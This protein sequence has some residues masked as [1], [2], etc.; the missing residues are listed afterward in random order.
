MK[1]GLGLCGYACTPWIWEPVTEYLNSQ[2]DLKLVSWPTS[3]L[4]H[5]H[6]VNDFTHWVIN[7]QIT[8]CRFIIGHSMGGLVATQ[9]AALTPQIEQVILLDSFVTT[10]TN[11][12]QMLFLPTLGKPIQNKIINM[13]N[14]ERIHY[15]PQL[16]DNLRAIHLNETLTKLDC[17]ITALYGDRGY[18]QLQQLISQLNWSPQLLNK[19]SLY[20]IANAGH[21]PMLEN[22]QETAEILLK[23][24][25]KPF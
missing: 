21:F 10:P 13:L 18:P 19:I 15:S 1:T 14:L 16:P 3:L 17:K 4:P 24:L 5:F 20:F 22:P 9:I 12:F 6:T 23:V 8:N 11:F 7:H 25:N 2:L